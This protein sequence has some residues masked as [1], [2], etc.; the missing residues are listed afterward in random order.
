[1][2]G[3][4]GIGTSSPLFTAYSQLTV[5]STTAGGITIQAGAT[6]YSRLFF[7]KDDTSN[8]E[9]LLRYYH[10]DNSMQLF[11]SGS[12][13]MR[14]TAAG[15]VGIGTSSPS[16]KLSLGSPLGI[17]S[18][19]TTYS[20]NDQGSIMWSYEY[21]GIFPRHLDIIAA[22]S[23]DGTNGGSNIR[24]FTNPVTNAANSV[25]RMRITSAG[26][27]G[28]GTS[29]PGYKLEVNGTGYFTGLSVNGTANVSGVLT[30]GAFQG[31]A[32]QI[33]T[34]VGYGATTL[35][36]YDLNNLAEGMYIV[37][38]YMVRGGAGINE[39]YTQTWFYSRLPGGSAYVSTIASNGGPGNC[40]GGVSISGTTVSIGW[41]GQRGP[42]AITALRLRDAF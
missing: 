25:E 11:T 16:Q 28:I 29:S 24:F 1:M 7:A 22:G 6:D 12:E 26:N 32:G 2:S 8:V 27:V 37:T 30:A 31:I 42:A 36:A 17:A 3:S 4:V 18:S 34:S 20:S 39:T 21:A 19:A 5:K 33:V 13:R 14:I 9:G 35:G 40:Y 15:N 10:L 23:P 41:C 38:G